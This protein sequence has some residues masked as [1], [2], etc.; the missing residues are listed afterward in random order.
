MTTL[1][2]SHREAIHIRALL[3]WEAFDS[4]PRSLTEQ[5]EADT[6]LAKINQF[7]DCAPSDDMI[8][9]VSLTTA[10]CFHLARR[11]NMVC[12]FIEGEYEAHR[13]WIDETRR[14]LHTIYTNLYNSL[15]QF[16]YE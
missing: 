6:I 13:G 15:I 14:D 10:E 16:A 5:S 11:A 8:G 3:K 9:S 4:R 1:R 12:K 2:Y 7:C